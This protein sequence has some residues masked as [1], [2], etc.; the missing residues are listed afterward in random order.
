MKNRPVA[1]ILVA[2]LDRSDLMTRLQRA[3]PTEGLVPAKV[4]FR[5][6][7]SAL[8]L[9]GDE[10]PQQVDGLALGVSGAGPFLS[11][12]LRWGDQRFHQRTPTLIVGTGD[13]TQD[14]AAARQILGREHVQWLAPEP[15]PQTLQPWLLKVVEVEA[16]RRRRSEHES[17]AHSLRRL[18]MGLFHGAD[19]EL[20]VPESPPCGPPLPTSISEVEPLKEARARF[21]RAH[22]QAVIEGFDSLKDASAALGISYTSLWRRLR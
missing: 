21:E 17:V 12:V 9:M 2:V 8:D 13:E 11:E 14:D 6:F 18:R 19:P 16:I 5:P 22:I 20:Q 4:E 3:L 7:E 10:A 15:G 1:E